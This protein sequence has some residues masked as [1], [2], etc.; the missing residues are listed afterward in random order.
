M[1][2]KLLCI[3]IVSLF[4]SG[5]KS[6]STPDS[7]NYQIYYYGNG[8]KSSEGFLEDG[9]PNHYWKSYNQQGVLISEGNRKD[10]L[11]DSTWKFYT[12]KGDLSLIINYKE[13]KRQGERIVFSP[14]EFVVERWDNDTLL[15]P[16]IA[17]YP[18]SL[19]KRITPYVEERLHGMEKEYNRDS[20]IIAVTTYYRGVLIRKEFINRTDNFGYKQGNWK[21]FWDNGNLRLEGAYRNDK[22][23]GFFKY[24]DENGEFLS[25]EKYENDE[26]IADAEETKTLDRKVNYHPNGQPKII[27]TYYND[28]PEGIRREFDTAGNIIQGYVFSNGVLRFEGITDM[29]G[30]RQGDWKEYYPTGELRWTG[31][32]RNSA[33]IGEWKFYF[34]DK[35]VETIG[36][37]NN[38]GEKIGEWTWHYSDGS[39][40]RIENYEVGELDGPFV[41]Y[42]ENGNVIAKG[43]YLGDE[44]EGD[45]SYVHGNITEKGRYYDGQREGVWKTWFADGTVASEIYYDAD[46]PSGKFFF[47][48]ENGKTRMTGRYE[49]GEPAGTWYKYD[50]N[51]NL[52]LSTVY[53]DGKEFMWNSYTIEN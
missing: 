31:K 9:K 42:D 27:A 53:R 6:Q 46:V 35:T 20:I 33:P 3:I 22:K 51:G 26:L 29:N 2:R 16:V 45:W 50:E 5:L 37:Y 44:K 32:Y 19:L 43:D 41:E 1:L 28:L 13:G 52:I 25:I 23:H 7:S 12:A 24:Y 40:M 49:G 4:I 15:S 14:D 48:W 21:Y 36:Q 34:P 38:K 11:L 18:D 47:N 39:V 30:K 8:Q 10:F 17:Y